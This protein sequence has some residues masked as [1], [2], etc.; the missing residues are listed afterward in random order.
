MSTD[1]GVLLGA[2][3]ELVTPLAAVDGAIR[4]RNLVRMQRL[5]TEHGLRLRPHA[6]THKSAAV[7][8]YSSRPAPQD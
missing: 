6:K 4:Q 7:A 1:L 3:A 2:T 8:P 5:A